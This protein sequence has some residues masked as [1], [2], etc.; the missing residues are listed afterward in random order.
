[1]ILQE[2]DHYYERLAADPEQEIAAAGYSVQQIGFVVILERDGRLFDIRLADQDEKGKP[3]SKKLVVPGQSKPPG[4]GINPCLFWDNA[5]YMLGLAPEGRDA[6]WVGKRFEAFRKRHLAIEKEVDDPFFAAACR[7]MEQWSPEAAAAREGLREA[8]PNF[9]VFQLRGETGYLHEQPAVKAWWDAQ[10]DKPADDDQDAAIMGQCLVTGKQSRLARLHEPA[11]KP[12]MGA[13]SSGAKLVSFNDDAYESYGKS[14]CFNAA[15]SEEAAFKYATALN[16]LLAN[17]ERRVIIGDATTVFWTEKPE[18]VEHSW[19]IMIE[20]R[21]AESDAQAE[22]VKDMLHRIRQGSGP[23]QTLGEP[24]TRFFV[25]GISPNAARLSVRYWLTGSLSQLHDR[26][27]R[28]LED[29]WIVG[30]SEED[31][32]PVV[33]ELMIETVRDPK[34]ISPELSGAV[35]RSIL[36]GLPYPQLLLNTVLRRIRND[37][38]R[39]S[40]MRAAILKACINRDLR[41]HRILNKESIPMS[42]DPQRTD[43]AYVLGRLFATYEKTQRDALGDKLNRTIRD[44]YF[45]SASASPASVFP[46]LSRL[47]QHHLSKMDN[48]GLRTNRDKLLGEL[49]GKINTFPTHLPLR[50]QGEFAIGYYHQMQSFYTKKNTESQEE[51]ND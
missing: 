23:R 9:G 22:E 21:Q 32:P 35:V 42:L 45:S 17:R 31:K 4:A 8:S 7:F 47:S 20:S 24:E 41:H 27:R 16:K 13:Q 1:M 37:G 28:H 15:V 50:D 2:L 48:P 39:V 26:I 3:R 25:L 19:G 43:T 30:M 18:P 40:T 36:A 49:Y 38:G 14:Q 29:L 6:A 51:N 10:L 46:R 12:V 11:I 44:S 34:D 5:T 33:R